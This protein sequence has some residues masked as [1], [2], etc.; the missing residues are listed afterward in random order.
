MDELEQLAG[1]MK[2]SLE[3]NTVVLFFVPRENTKRIAETLKCMNVWQRYGITPIA[4]P[5]DIIV[6]TLPP[7]SDFIVSRDSSAK[8]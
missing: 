5:D 2:M 4:V 1:I 8:P 3:R 6:Q 7:G